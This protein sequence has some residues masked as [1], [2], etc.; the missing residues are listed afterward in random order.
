MRALRPLISMMSD[1]ANHHTMCET[2]LSNNHSWNMG[3]RLWVVTKI[4]LIHVVFVVVCIDTVVISII[5][6][7]FSVFFVLFEWFSCICSS[8]MKCFLSWQLNLILDAEKSSDWFWMQ[9]YTYNKI[10]KT[11]N[12][13]SWNRH[14]NN[15]YR[16]FC[17]KSFN[18]VANGVRRMKMFG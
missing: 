6:I 9:N 15:K 4:E 7:L 13:F 3:R 1:T 18:S 10:K 14:L 11:L 2:H 8:R 17:G 16:L 12:L 5:W